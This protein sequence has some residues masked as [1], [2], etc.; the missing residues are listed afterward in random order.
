VAAV[1]EENRPSLR[2]FEKAGF[3]YVRD[4]EEDGRPH[5]LLRLGR[6]A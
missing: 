2:A 1:D 6:G 3:R 5:R 4:V